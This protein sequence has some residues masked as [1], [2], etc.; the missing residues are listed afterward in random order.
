M[1]TF[2]GSYENRPVAKKEKNSGKSITEKAGYIPTKSLIENMFKAGAQLSKV[3]KEMYS[4]E[5]DVDDDSPPNPLNR[6]DLDLAESSKLE[7]EVATKVVRALNEQQKNT[8]ASAS[9]SVPASA[10]TV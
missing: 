4:S 10:P 1:A 2:K 6:M 3:R 9:V 7:R 5:N 8:L